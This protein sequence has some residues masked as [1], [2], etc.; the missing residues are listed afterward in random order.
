MGLP[1]R[2]RALFRQSKLESEIDE[3]LR[4]HVEMREKANIGA[5]MSAEDAHFDARRRFG[6]AILLRERTRDIDLL[7]FFETA[8]QDLR[9]GVRT[10][11]RNP[12]VTVVAVSTLA[13]GV[14]ANTAIFSLLNALAIRHLPVP[15]PEQLVRVGAH[16]PD[17]PF[18]A[19]SLPMFEEF[20][21]D[22][23][24][25]SDMF[26]WWGNAV[27]NAETDGVLSRADVW[28][29]TGSFHSQLSAVPEIGRVLMPA[30]V[31]LRAPPAQVAV[32]GY[33][34]WQRH[35]GGA[36]DVIGK[37]IKVEGV[38][39]TVIG[40]TRRGV[41]GISAEEEPEITVPITAEPLFFGGPGDVQKKLNRRDTRWLEAAGRLKPGV[42]LEQARAQL[43]SLWLSIRQAMA[44]LDRTSTEG[45]H[46]MALKLKVESGARGASFLRGQFTKSL[47]LLL[48][49]SSVVLLLTCV[50]IASL[51]LARAASRGHELGV[52]AA[53]GASRARL[54][55][56]MLT[57]SLAL[58]IAGSLAG[59]GLAFW[60]SSALAAFIVGQIF[61]VPSAALNLSP[62]WRVFG[63]TAAAAILTGV[64]FGLAPAW[65]AV[66]EDPHGAVQRGARTMASG[67]GFLGKALIVAQVALSIILV[68]GAGL[69]IRTVQKL[70]AV[71]PGFRTHGALD[72][73]LFP[74]PGGYTNL[75]RIGYYHMLTD[76]IARLPGVAAAGLVHTRPAS[77]LP[78]TEKIRISKTG[79]E[80]IRAN[81][82]MLMPGAFQAMGI[83]LLRGRSFTWQ[84]D[85]H[86]PRIAIVSKNLEEKL[87]PQSA[88]I[89]R[90]LDITTLPKWQ[91]LQIVGIVSNASLYD[92]RKYEPPTLYL[93]SMQ[94]GDYMGWSDLFVQTRISPMAL[95]EPIQR[96][97]ESS[98]HEYVASTTTI[99]QEIDRS[100]YRE[101]ITAMLSAFFGGLALLL[102]AI[103]LYGLMAYYVSRRSREIAIRIAVGAPRAA[104]QRMVI[105]ETLALAWIGVTVGVP[106]G[107]V[108]SKLIAGMLYGVSPHDPLTFV[109][110]S[111]MLMAIAAI[112]GLVPARRAI[113]LDP[114]VAL[115]CE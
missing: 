35:Y 40:V 52:R 66:H 69:L 81:V 112:A 91:N 53:L 5:G 73:H 111:L 92:L 28:A 76:R 16:S 82:E 18:T 13:L 32:L 49:I 17:D 3:E 11:V 4:F 39:F 43:E 95:A 79:A 103:G 70:Y 61:V 31:N 46:F 60:G 68:T 71:E 100:L 41:T 1:N 21:R 62:D 67:T 27:L 75:A 59:F 2:F 107:I 26:A 10:L 86:R 8:I 88:A 54:V 30:D 51:M 63:F 108:S 56:Q 58:S 7:V 15:H 34:F 93:P 99:E 42:T 29:V 113:R 19:L 84:D 37:V 44:P 38:P 50:N 72:A 23:K 83:G 89:G 48:A 65:R 6:N 47:Y 20:A 24:V 101:R 96:A 110:V 45:R 33:G 74:K 114:I 105:R 55:R 78:W 64:L 104:V 115:R 85:E 80:E 97:V 57:E 36:R 9:F 12:T 102:A 22:Q 109:T 25:F 106:C 94:Y 98:G 14:G 77:I 87:F 90:Q